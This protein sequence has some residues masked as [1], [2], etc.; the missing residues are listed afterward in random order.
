MFVDVKS[1]L[2]CSKVNNNM[3]PKRRFR[4]SKSEQEEKQI[5]W[6]SV[7][8]SLHEALQSGISKYFPNGKLHEPTKIPV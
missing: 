5:Y 1:V 7:S 4:S 6:K 8:L 3:P 2:S